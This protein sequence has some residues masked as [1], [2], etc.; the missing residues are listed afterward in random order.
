MREHYPSSRKYFKHSSAITSLCFAPGDSY[1]IL[2]GLDNGAIQRYDLRYQHISTGRVWGA[3]G[4]KAV[5]D[6][7]WKPEEHDGEWLASAGADR[8]VQVRETL[9]SADQKVWDMSQSWDRPPT[10][11]HSLHTAYPLRRLAWRPGHE[12]EL[13]IVPLEAPSSSGPSDPSADSVQQGLD[14]HPQDGDAH[15]EIWDVRRH[16]VA[17]F[18]LPTQ[19]GSAV[20]VAWT[21]DNLIACFRDGVFAQLDLKHR[22]IPLEQVPRQIMA[23]SA[24]EELAYG[25]DRFKVGEIPFDDL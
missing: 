21:Y 19:D 18:A 4:N 11:V 20:E 9:D 25:L 8:T 3:H 22:T 5:M 23:W 13:V 6:L 16:Y 1:Q 14:L 7:K 12:T 2:V 15:L 24:R 10:P 17:K